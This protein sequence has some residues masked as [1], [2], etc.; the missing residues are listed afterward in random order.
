M[1]P[2]WKIQFHRTDNGRCQVLEEFI[3]SLT[4]PDQVRVRSLLKKVEQHGPE[5]DEFS[6]YL[7]RS[8]HS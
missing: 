3:P 5:Y 2:T 8:G 1:Q 7:A 6:E 4:S